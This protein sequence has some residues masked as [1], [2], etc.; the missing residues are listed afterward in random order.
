M[1]SQDLQI[2]VWTGFYRFK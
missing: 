2:I 1:F